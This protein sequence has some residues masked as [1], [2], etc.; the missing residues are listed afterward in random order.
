MFQKKV[1][2]KSKHK[3]YVQKLFFRKSCPLLNNVKK[4]GTATQAKDDNIIRR[5]RV[6]CRIIKAINTHKQNM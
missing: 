6:A 4:Y 3:F 5:M 1:E 2:R